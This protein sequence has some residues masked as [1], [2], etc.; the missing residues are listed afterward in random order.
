M[1][2]DQ[3]KNVAANL[4]VER[5]V[6]NDTART[7]CPVYRL[8]PCK[9]G[10]KRSWIKMKMDAKNQYAKRSCC[11]AKIASCLACS[12]GMSVRK[13]CKKNPFTAGCKRKKCSKCSRVVCTGRV[14]KKKSGYVQEDGRCTELKPKSCEDPPVCCKARIAKCAA[15][16]AGTSVEEYCKK[17]P[18]TI[19]CKRPNICATVKCIRPKCKRGER[20]IRP[21]PRTGNCCGKC[22][23]TPPVCCKARIAKCAAC[24]AGTSVEKYCKKYPFTIGCKGP[25]I[26][27]TV[28]C[29][30][31]K[32]KRGE[33]YIKPIQEQEI[34]V[35]NV[36][37][38]RLIVKRVRVYA[39]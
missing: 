22:V 14:C 23:D 30:I 16:R 39:Q 25:N 36:L 7:K 28:K 31:P 13:Y 2:N 8:A 35:E 24:R 33:R 32:C 17:H 1:Q 20:Y 26:C 18:F 19:G 12:A 3:E 11:R 10:S 21:N 37:R 6:V 15:C 38:D 5:Y 4:V 34:V 27:A 29:T 9:G